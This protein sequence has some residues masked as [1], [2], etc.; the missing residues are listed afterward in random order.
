MT[1]TLPTVSIKGNQYVLVKDRVAYF[2]EKYPNGMIQTKVEQVEKGLW[3]CE[4]IVTPDADFPGRFFTGHSQAREDSSM[5][6]KTSA[7]ENCE[8]SAVGRALAM[9]G[10]GVIESIASADEVHKAVNQAPS[11]PSQPVLSGE[12]VC[13]IHNIQ[14]KQRIAPAGG[15]YFDH[16]HQNTTGVWEKCMGM[17]YK[18]D[19]V[20]QPIVKEDPATMEVD[21]TEIPDFF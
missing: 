2:N 3:V 5:I 17:G 14:M 13:T 10:I 11:A 1:D 9:M 19:M 8:T 15:I 16:R 7:A 21:P 18:A 20:R 12:H 6:N 4:S